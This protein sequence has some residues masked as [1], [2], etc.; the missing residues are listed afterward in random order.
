MKNIS[1]LIMIFMFAS[2]AKK[3]PAHTDTNPVKVMKS[4]KAELTAKAMKANSVAILTKNLDLIYPNDKKS[5]KVMLIGE[6]AKLLFHSMKILVVNIN[7]SEF[8]KAMNQKKGVDI[9]CVELVSADDTEE[10]TYNCEFEIN[11][12]T[13]DVTQ[14]L[15][16]VEEDSQAPELTEVATTT[17]ISINPLSGHESV[18]SLKG[19][20][21]LSLNMM[22]RVDEVENSNGILEKL[23]RKYYCLTT[24]SKFSDDVIVCDFHFDYK[25][26]KIHPANQS[27]NFEYAN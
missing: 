3:N 6:D 22:M 18:I 26:G 23:G 25:T 20:S 19:N 8:Y 2:C 13:A 9:S 17:N 14:L 15:P 7:D 10:T 21:A 12:E 5:G 24:K 16:S 27:G 1:Y 11:Y 4:L